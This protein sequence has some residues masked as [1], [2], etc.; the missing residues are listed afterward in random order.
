MSK[1]SFLLVSSY[2]PLYFTCF[3]GGTERENAKTTVLTAE[4]AKIWLLP[5][6]SV[7]KTLKKKSLLQ[8]LQKNLFLLMIFGLVM[9]FKGLRPRT[10][11]QWH[12]FC[13]LFWGT[14]LAWGGTILVWGAQPRNAL[15]TPGLCRTRK[16]RDSEQLGSLG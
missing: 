15:L 12:Q 3:D 16:A 10:A 6:I 5:S 4:S 11:L 2:F 14:I 13:Y 9:Y 8:N 7:V 1:I